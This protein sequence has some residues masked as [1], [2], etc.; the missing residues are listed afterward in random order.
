[1]PTKSNRDLQ[2]GNVIVGVSNMRLS[3]LTRIELMEPMTRPPYFKAISISFLE[4]LEPAFA[5]KLDTGLLTDAMAASAVKPVL[6]S[7]LSNE[8]FAVRFCLASNLTAALHFT[9]HV[10]GQLALHTRAMPTIS[11]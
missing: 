6:M 1:M 10:F 8:V 7:I 3:A 11:L 9:R 5:M 2:I 4:P